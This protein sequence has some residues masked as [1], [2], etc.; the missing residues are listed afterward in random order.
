MHPPSKQSTSVSA[1]RSGSGFAAAGLAKP[2]E[3]PARLLVPGGP[4]QGGE[5]GCIVRAFPGVHTQV[6]GSSHTLL[7]PD[8]PASCKS[9]GTNS[10]RSPKQETV[11]HP[12]LSK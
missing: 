10:P 7:V 3:L 4:G 1:G 8:F 11:S 9:T 12:F 5:V 2:W 6:R